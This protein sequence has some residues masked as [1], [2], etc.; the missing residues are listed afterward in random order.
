MFYLRPSLNPLTPQALSQAF[1]LCLNP[2][3]SISL[4][5]SPHPLSSIS[6]LSSV[7]SPF[8]F[9]LTQVSPLTPQVLSQAFPQSP[10]P[11]GSF[12]L[13]PFLSLLT[14]QV[15][16]RAI[17]LSHQATLKN[18][19]QSAGWHKKKSVGRSGL[20]FFSLSNFSVFID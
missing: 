19:F 5:L 17:P 20:F 3:G 14:P 8:R 16:S 4:S 15:L 2:S 1:P 10:H 18:R 9:Y 13:R 12:S 6:G 11:S 7:P